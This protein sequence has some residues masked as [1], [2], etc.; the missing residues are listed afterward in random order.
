M[1]RIARI[2]PPQAMLHII[3]RSN[4]KIR[5]FKNADDFTQFRRT[6]LK[7]ISE[8]PIFIHHYI[9]MHTHVHIL[10]W[11]DDTSVLAS[12]MKCIGVSYNHYYRRN[13]GFHGHLWHGRFRTV[14]IESESHWAACGRYI[15]LNPVRANICQ[16]PEKYPWSSY[17]YYAFGKE[18]P[19]LRPIK[20][21]T[22]CE[23]WVPGVG[24]RKYR[25][26]VLDGMKM[27]QNALKRL[28]SKK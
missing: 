20:G 4:N 2:I 7:Y 17:H 16:R 5:M 21:M 25:E 28:Y 14:V 8:V 19:L 6:I 18:D 23:K 27:D 26:F 12:I 24:S 3:G 9:F 10:A 15:E 1:P 11:V 22:M 13:Y